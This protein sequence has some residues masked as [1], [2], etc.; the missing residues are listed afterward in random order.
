[1]P[2]L[3][4][5]FCISG[6][7]ALSPPNK[8]QRPSLKVTSWLLVSGGFLLLPKGLQANSGSFSQDGPAL[9]RWMAVQNALLQISVKGAPATAVMTTNVTHF[10]M[11][12]VCN[13]A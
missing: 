13:E 7:T 1:M 11:D 4:K 5:G 3:T 8:N 6:I 10:M 12:L 9:S 2:L